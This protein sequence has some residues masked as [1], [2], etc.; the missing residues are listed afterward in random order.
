[1]T[2]KPKKRPG[3][4]RVNTSIVKKI[5]LF[6]V[7]DLNFYACFLCFYELIL[8]SFAVFFASGYLGAFSSEQGRIEPLGNKN[9]K[10]LALLVYVNMTSSKFVTIH[11][12]FNFCYHVTSSAPTYLPVCCKMQRFGR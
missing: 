8:S 1:M 9:F 10:N 4:N 3:L 12:F 6:L 5:K 2:R 7:T 11:F